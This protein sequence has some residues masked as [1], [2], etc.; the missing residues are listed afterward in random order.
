MGESPTFSLTVLVVPAGLAGPFELATM[1]GAEGA[2]TKVSLGLLEVDE[3]LVAVLRTVPE[4][5]VTT[6]TLGGVMAT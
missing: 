4:G 2:P 5:V 6:T 3:L 1:W